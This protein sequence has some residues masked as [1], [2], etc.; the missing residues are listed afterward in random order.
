[1]TDSVTIELTEDQAQAID[2]FIREQ[3][4]DTSRAEACRLLLD[5]AL[6]G[7]GYMAPPPRHGRGR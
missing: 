7:A 1:M 3:R 4:P 6:V 5:D 2:Q